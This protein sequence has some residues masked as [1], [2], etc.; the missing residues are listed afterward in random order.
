[1]GERLIAIGGVLCGGGLTT[2]SAFLVLS[3]QDKSVDP[4]GWPM[5][6]SAALVGVGFLAMIVGL[7]LRARGAHSLIQRQ[8]GGRGS[9]NIQVGGDMNIQGTGR[10]NAE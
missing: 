10:T 7:F 8:R 1:M 6:L 2:G 3:A 9:T 4:W 5:W